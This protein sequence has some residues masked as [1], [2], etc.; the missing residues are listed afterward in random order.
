MYVETVE[1]I[2]LNNLQ[3]ELLKLF[4]L[5]SIYYEQILYISQ[6][7]NHVITN[8]IKRCS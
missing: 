3:N 6:P 8:V 7:E 1:S 5:L 4:I 2:L